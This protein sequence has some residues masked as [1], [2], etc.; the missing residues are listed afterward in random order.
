M[1]DDR[2]TAEIL[3]EYFASVFTVEDVSCIPNAKK[4]F[5]GDLDLKG[6][7]NLNIDED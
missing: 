2:E 5:K 6:L 3:N 1:I 7:N 4:E